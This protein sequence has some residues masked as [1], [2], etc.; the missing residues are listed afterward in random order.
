MASSALANEQGRRHC[1]PGLF[2]CPL[3]PAAPLPSSYR[4]GPNAG[5]GRD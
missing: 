4:P 3:A 1:V 2:F 5:R